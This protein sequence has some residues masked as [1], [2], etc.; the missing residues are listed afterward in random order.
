MSPLIPR[1]QRG[2]ET[3]PVVSIA[4][5]APLLCAPTTPVSSW[6]SPVHTVCK[7]VV[8]LCVELLSNTNA[9]LPVACAGYACCFVDQRKRILLVLPV[10]ALIPCLCVSPFGVAGC[11]NRML[12]L[13]PTLTVTTPSPCAQKGACAAL[14]SLA[15]WLTGDRCLKPGNQR[16]LPC[17]KKFKLKVIVPMVIIKFKS[18]NENRGGLIKLTYSHGAL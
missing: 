14:V 9:C 13:M 12:V 2:V 17:G 1:R 11:V 7:S 6:N 16:K 18:C 10:Q 15:A 8:T 5:A 3:E 4:R